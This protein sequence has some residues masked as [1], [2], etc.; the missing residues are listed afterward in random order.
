MN[1]YLLDTNG[2]ISFVIQRVPEQTAS[3]SARLESA[4]NLECEI[5]I[6]PFVISEFV[7][8]LS[9][10]YERTDSELKEMVS[11][12]FN[13]PGIKIANPYNPE[14]LLDLWPEKI[15]DYGDALTAMAALELNIPVLTF[16]KDFIKHLRKANIQFEK[17]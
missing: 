6:T 9:S 15:K 14:K 7:Y 11:D 10:V 4:A 12:L 16:D 1:S 8:V 5:V 2:L 13:T 3:I 17:P